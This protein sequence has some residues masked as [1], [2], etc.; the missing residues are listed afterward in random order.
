M[1]VVVA[2]LLGACS[3]VPNERKNSY[4]MPTTHPYGAGVAFPDRLSPVEGDVS[5]LGWRDP[6]VDFRKYRQFLFE[7][8]RI[9][10]DPDSPAVDPEDRQALAGYF[11]KALTAAVEPPYPVVEKGAP[12]VLRV[13]ITILDLVSTRAGG[14]GWDAPPL[15]GR[16]GI[17][18]DFVDGATGNVVAEFT[19]T[20]PGRKDGADAGKALPT[21]ADAKLAFDQWSRRFRNQIDLLNGR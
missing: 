6:A 18:V 15:L 2:L 9:S 16:T 8:I 1:G 5:A 21:W 19:D 17:A 12:D 7:P 14:G 13:R 20:K 4:N 10:L 3:T 11:R